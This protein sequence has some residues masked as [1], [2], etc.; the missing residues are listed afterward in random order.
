MGDGHTVMILSSLSLIV[1]EQST[2]LGTAVQYDP[3][4]C[5]PVRPWVLLSSTTLGTAVQCNGKPDQA[6]HV[7]LLYLMVFMARVVVFLFRKKRK[8][9][10]KVLSQRVS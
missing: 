9:G 5:C 6:L 3:G 4:Y 7:P 2:T 1:A 8:L 10:D